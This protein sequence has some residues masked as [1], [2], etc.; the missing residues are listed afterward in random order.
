M[1]YITRFDVTRLPVSDF[2][3]VPVSYL[4]SGQR[5]FLQK[6]L[7]S[8]IWSSDAVWLPHSSVRNDSL[9]TL[10]E[11][12]LPLKKKKNRKTQLEV[13]V[14]HWTFPRFNVCVACVHRFFYNWVWRFLLTCPYQL[15][16]SMA[17]NTCGLQKTT[18]KKAKYR[19]KTKIDGCRLSSKPAACRSPSQSDR[20]TLR[21]PPARKWCRQG[22]LVGNAW[23]DDGGCLEVGG[24]CLSLCAHQ[25]F[26]TR[27]LE[28]TP[29]PLCSTWILALPGLT[30]CW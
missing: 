7:H 28:R 13:A 17:A 9:C 26:C 20:T 16:S 12:M 18:R 11:T 10:G 27:A 8:W 2:K 21:F 3:L 4:Y 23:W 30:T 6:E 19:N 24:S 15:Y 29:P 5:W 14:G 25:H 22:F 1:Q